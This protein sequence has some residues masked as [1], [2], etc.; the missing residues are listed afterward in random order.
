MQRRQNI[1]NCGSHGPAVDQAKSRKG[2]LPNLHGNFKGMERQYFHY[3]MKRTKNKKVQLAN[4][5]ENSKPLSS[6]SS[7]ISASGEKSE[8]RQAPASNIRP[9]INA[10]NMSATEI[11]KAWP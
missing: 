10:Q 3:S 8:E 9:E 11:E 2:E 7:G 1:S 6:S 5:Y 4:R